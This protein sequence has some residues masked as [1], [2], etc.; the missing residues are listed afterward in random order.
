M[1]RKI[2]ELNTAVRAK[3]VELGLIFVSGPDT[4]AVDFP[5]FPS[6]AQGQTNGQPRF[7]YLFGVAESEPTAAAR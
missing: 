1:H 5:T 4:R 7:V 3:A 6:P 2:E